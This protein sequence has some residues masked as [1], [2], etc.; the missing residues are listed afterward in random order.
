MDNTNLFDV[1]CVFTYFEIKFIMG[2][3]ANL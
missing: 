3:N 1:T 2:L